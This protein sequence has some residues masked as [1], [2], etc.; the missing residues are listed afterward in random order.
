MKKL[1]CC[2]GSLLLVAMLLSGCSTK[3]DTV[4]I[5][6]SFG[7]GSAAR[8]PMEQGFMEERAKELGD[9][10]EV[11]LNK[12]DTPRTQKEDCFEMI[13]GGID[14]LILT[15]RDVNN[16]EEILAYAKKKNV[17]VINYARVVLGDAVDLFVGY[18]SRRIGQSMGQYLSEKVYTGD[19][20]ILRGDP[21]DYNATLLYEGAM[22]YIDPIKGG[23]NIIMDEAVPDWS[24]DMAK[25]MVKSSVAQ[26]GNHVDAILAPNDRLAGASADALAELG[27][28]TPVVITGMDAD[29]DAVKRIINGKQDMTV[30]MD[31]KDLARKAVE[32]A[33]KMGRNQEADV[34]ADF[35]NQGEST[36]ASYLI[37]GQVVTNK[38]IDKILIEKGYYTKEAVYGN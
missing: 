20:I 32:E 13:D 8:W 37:N 2:L 6:V 29:L 35:D 11:R 28:T 24:V 18:D 36:V 12:T 27:V 30:Y 21:A 17:K 7:V 31:L 16:T 1:L 9:D 26:N 15:P 3:E 23:V 10:I 14:V 5:G 4:K 22:R 33:D 19:Y 25:E 38:N 34:N